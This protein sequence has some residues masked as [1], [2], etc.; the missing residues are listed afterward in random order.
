MS[1]HRPPQKRHAARSIRS[2]VSLHTLA[3][4][5]VEIIAAGRN[6]ILSLQIN[7]DEPTMAI[8]NL[9]LGPGK[10]KGMWGIRANGQLR[11]W[12]VDQDGRIQWFP[13]RSARK[14]VKKRTPAGA[15]RR[16]HGE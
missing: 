4:G 3:D 10:Y 7:A 2:M 12:V 11:G 14:P 5:S 6:G 8:P 13:K 1:R 15:K 9:K 16:R